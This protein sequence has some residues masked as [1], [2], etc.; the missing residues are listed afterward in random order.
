MMV[1]TIYIVQHRRIRELYERRPRRE[2][3]RMCL[4]SGIAELV[5]AQAA[6]AGFTPARAHGSWVVRITNC[7]FYIAQ[8]RRLL[9]RCERHARRERR[10]ERLRAGIADPV[11]P[12]AG[13][14]GLKPRAHGS[15]W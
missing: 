1:R 10:R 14:V 13:K 7:A 11:R 4:S 6:R 9:E 15:W 5:P 8:H 12:Q 3:R 2:R